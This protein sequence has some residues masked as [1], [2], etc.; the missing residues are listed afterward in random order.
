MSRSLATPNYSATFVQERSVNATAQFAQK[1]SASDSSDE[2]P[3]LNPLPFVPLTPTEWTACNLVTA[4]CGEVVL[5]FWDQPTY[6]YE[7]LDGNPVPL[8]A[9][10]KIR[11]GSLHAG[12]FSS[13]SFHLVQVNGGSVEIEFE[14]RWV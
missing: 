14:G 10:F 9:D 2:D 1:Q 8:Q 6:P 3:D 13:G 11:T 5:N 12:L 4:E 7:D